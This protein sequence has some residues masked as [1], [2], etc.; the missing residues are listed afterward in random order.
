MNSNAN[1]ARS[2][3]LSLQFS[4]SICKKKNITVF[5]L[6]AIC[7]FQNL[8]ITERL[9]DP[10]GLRKGGLAAAGPRNFAANGARPRGFTRPVIYLLAYFN[11]N[12][13]CSLS[14]SMGTSY[15][16]ILHFV[17]IKLG[18]YNVYNHF[19]KSRVVN[20]ALCFVS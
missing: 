13:V 12:F 6:M 10:R 4:L 18:S 9:R 2:V 20:W 3:F 5:T 1:S 15:C 19:F 16:E 14:V 7:L 17:S 11:F 8:Q